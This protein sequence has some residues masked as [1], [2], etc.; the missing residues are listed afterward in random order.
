MVL[1]LI[2]IKKRSCL[3]NMKTQISFILADLPFYTNK[4]GLL[5]EMKNIILYQFV[6]NIFFIFVSLSYFLF[7]VLA[8]VVPIFFFLHLFV[9]VVALWWAVRTS[10]EEHGMA[11]DIYPLHVDLSF[12]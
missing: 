5:G 10:N 9:M 7:L 4:G 3:K 2:Q 1:G 6:V 8:G 12:I 11:R